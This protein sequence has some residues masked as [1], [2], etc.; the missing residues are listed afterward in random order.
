VIISTLLGERYLQKA[1][2]NITKVHHPPTDLGTFP[3]GGVARLV[4]VYGIVG[5]MALR[6]LAPRS[7]RALVGGVW[8]LT[9]LTWIEGYSRIHLQKHWLFDPIG[10][11][12][13]GVGILAV[14]L[15]ASTLLPWPEPAAEDPA[16]H[17]GGRRRR[18]RAPTRLR[19]GHVPLS[20]D[21]VGEV[22]LDGIA[23][24]G[25]PAPAPPV[26]EAQ[27][28]ELVSLTKAAADQTATDASLGRA[29]AARIRA[30]RVGQALR[31]VAR[32]AHVTSEATLQATGESA[33]ATALDESP[34]DSVDEATNDAVGESTVDTVVEDGPV[35]EV[36]A[37]LPV[38]E[39]P[40]DESPAGAPTDDA[41][42][43]ADDAAMGAN[44][45]P[46]K[47]ASGLVE[48]ATATRPRKRSSK[49]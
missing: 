33:D 39:A 40:V 46:E 36:P 22:V 5:F 12:I 10:G 49:S 6:V 17:R 23:E 3:S 38:E 24:N 37:G 20:R 41:A 30:A 4:C 31:R 43:D 32:S 35:D 7:R 2:T 44:P 47:P 14:A 29:R 21:E 26:A 9:L 18:Q 13:L 27:H 28:D 11:L 42:S 34:I 1:I 15:A 8:L 48:G 45:E 19:A 25:D 16:R